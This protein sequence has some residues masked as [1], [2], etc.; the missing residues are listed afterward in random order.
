MG[1]GASRFLSAS[2]HAFGTPFCWIPEQETHKLRVSL[3]PA[4][5]RGVG[6]LARPVDDDFVIARVAPL[7]PA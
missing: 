1:G 5:V 2:C 3:R 6:A 4:T 7:A